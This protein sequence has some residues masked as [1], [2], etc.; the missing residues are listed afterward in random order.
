MKSTP[1]K[2]ELAALRE[3]AGRHPE[4]GNLD[5]QVA[6]LVVKSRR[7]TGVG[8][9]SDFE[10]PNFVAP[11]VGCPRAN[12][13]IN[14]FMSGQ[15]CHFILWPSSDARYIEQLEIVTPDESLPE[16]AT[17]ESFIA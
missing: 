7:Y 10:I 15:L 16:G 3:I 1:T 5:I 12:I 8:F 14:G 2:I 11:L 17:L 6:N 9:Y 13:M 4:I